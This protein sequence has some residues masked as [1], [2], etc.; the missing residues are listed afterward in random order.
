MIKN[1]FDANLLG[2][3]A[4]S[5]IMEDMIYEVGL[6]MPRLPKPKKPLSEYGKGTQH[7]FN[8][9][10]RY[11]SGKY[12][13]LDNYRYACNN[14]AAEYPEQKIQCP[15]KR[16]NFFERT[17]DAVSDAVG[18]VALA[19]ANPTLAL[20]I[21]T[22]PG[23]STALSKTA[24]EI[25]RSKI[26]QAALAILANP[27]LAQT[28]A[29][30]RW[31]KANPDHAMYVAAVAAAAATAGTS[32]A[33][34]GK[35][36]SGSL[37]AGADAVNQGLTSDEMKRNMAVV[38]T[39]AAGNML[40]DMAEGTGLDMSL[41]SNV[42]SPEKIT[43]EL[44]R[45]VA[46]GRITREQA[47][48]I[49]QTVSQMRNEGKTDQ[50]IINE[51]VNSQFFKSLSNRELSQLTYPVLYNDFMQHLLALDYDYQTADRVARQM[52]EIYA[53]RFAKSATDS[54]VQQTTK[55]DNWVWLALIPAA[56]LLLR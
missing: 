36:A 55:S 31:A 49:Q 47:N 53:A 42:I 27:M 24:A 9:Q 18:S 6:V 11:H 48:T 34:L 43:S 13:N 56:F 21:A 30:A 45:L 40:Y 12:F 3:G 29:E 10:D 51:L 20:N 5:G 46:D 39:Q 7:Y 14:V 33:A 26:A 2:S 37:A 23:A 25:E 50:Q 4:L 44:N 15:K 28:A 8:N 1:R 32:Y 52:A 35:V 19:V 41:L 17:G 54:V 16:D 38:G 22:T